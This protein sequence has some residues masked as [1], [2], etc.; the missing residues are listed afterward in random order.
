MMDAQNQWIWRALP[1]NHTHF[2][3]KMQPKNPGSKY[4]NP[5]LLG[6]WTLQVVDGRMTLK[7]DRTIPH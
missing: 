6:P 2:Y 5:W 1:L 3:T 4:G 7:L